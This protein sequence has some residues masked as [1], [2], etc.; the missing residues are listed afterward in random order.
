MVLQL[1]NIV[2]SRSYKTISLFAIVNTFSKT[3]RIA[4]TF[5]RK[6]Q[7]Q[8]LK[9]DRIGL[10]KSFLLVVLQ[11]KNIVRSKRYNTM[12]FSL[13]FRDSDHIFKNS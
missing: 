6:V 7:F 5:D 11:L 2:R 10:K 3:A 4:I 9:L 8:I 13:S 1:K 12:S